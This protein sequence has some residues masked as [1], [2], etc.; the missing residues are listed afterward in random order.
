MGRANGYHDSSK[1]RSPEMKI[2]GELYQGDLEGI[3]TIVIIKTVFTITLRTDFGLSFKVK[4]CNVFKLAL[5][6][7]G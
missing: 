6:I 1:E 2:G 3:Q 7:L 5:S 4:L